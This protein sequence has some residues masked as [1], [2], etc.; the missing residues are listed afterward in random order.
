MVTTMW[1]EPMDKLGL[2]PED[3]VDHSDIPPALA[4]Y[5]NSHSHV[6]PTS[7]GKRRRCLKY[8]SLYAPPHE[9]WRHDLEVGESDWYCTL[10]FPLGDSVFV[11]VREP[12]MEIPNGEYFYHKVA[13]RVS[14]NHVEIRNVTIESATNA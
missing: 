5:F 7:V 2:T 13:V 14:R 4:A 12:G 3:F 9:L 6:P 1:Y 11:L 8:T 10:W